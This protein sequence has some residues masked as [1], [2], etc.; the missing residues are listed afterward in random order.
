MKLKLIILVAILTSIIS[1]QK[2]KDSFQ[3]YLETNHSVKNF[4][5]N[6]FFSLAQNQNLTIKKIIA[7]LKTVNSKN[8]FLTEFVKVA[9]YPRWDKSIIKHGAEI[10][11]TILANKLYQ[12]NDTIC[13]IPLVSENN[14]AITGVLI[15]EVLNDQIKCR[16]SLLNNYKEMQEI[17]RMF[18]LSMIQLEKHVYGYT[19]F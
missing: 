17:Q 15:A 7:Y 1:C 14:T 8:E 5:Y 3:S 2:Q 4:D 12:E 9:G 6:R 18:V 16:Y 19:T 10:Q 13:V 11:Q